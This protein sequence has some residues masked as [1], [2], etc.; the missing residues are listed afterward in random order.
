MVESKARLGMF[1]EGNTVSQSC[2]VSRKETL[3]DKSSL[4]DVAVAL[5]Q[6][7]EQPPREQLASNLFIL[8]LALLY[9]VGAPVQW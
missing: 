6:H 7:G 1:G 4:I 9:C 3:V 2:L 5:G 8:C